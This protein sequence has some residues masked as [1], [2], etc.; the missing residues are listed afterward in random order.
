MAR[1]KPTKLVW[2][3]V[4]ICMVLFIADAFYHKHGP[5]GI[6]HLFGFFAI[7][8]FIACGALVLAAKWARTLLERPEDFYDADE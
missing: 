1:D 2:T 3:L 4:T 6:E 5:F 8:G 7:F